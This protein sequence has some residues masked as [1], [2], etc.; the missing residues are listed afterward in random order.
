[1][2]Q[3]KP[4][5]FF[6]G[7]FLII[8]LIFAYYYKTNIQIIHNSS[9]KFKPY[10]NEQSQLHKIERVVS[11]YPCEFIEKVPTSQPCDYQAK[12]RINI[13]IYDESFMSK[14]ELYVSRLYINTVKM[15]VLN[16]FYNDYF[17]ILDG[18]FYPQFSKSQGITMVGVRRL[19]NVQMILEDI[20]LRG[21]GGDF[22]ELGVFRGGLC[23]F[24]QAIFQ[25]FGSRPQT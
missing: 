13:G 7:S 23:I 3:I 20:I 11:K 1:M 8:F 24:A 9:K 15:S 22:I 10:E 4:K 14:E 17:G 25:I 6:G 5:S 18:S 2:A 19:D 21:I 16:V 12:L